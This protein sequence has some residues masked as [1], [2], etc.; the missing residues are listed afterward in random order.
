[1][2][3]VSVQFQVEEMNPI[4]WEVLEIQVEFSQQ[5]EFA[6]FDR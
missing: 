4:V 3:R 1:M 5:F 2:I 6:I